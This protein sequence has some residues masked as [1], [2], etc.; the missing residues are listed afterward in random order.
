LTL[1]IVTGGSSGIGAACARAFAARGHALVLLGRRADRLEDVARECRAAGAAE[2]AVRAADVRDRAALERW[3]Q[4][5]AQR[6]AGADVLVNNAGLARGFGPL[7]ENDPSHWDEMLD[8]N[9]RGLLDVTRLVV[10]GMIARGTGDV[11]NVGSVAGRWTYPGGAAYCA[12]KAA[13]RVITEGLRM[14][15]L[16]KG[17]RVSTVDPGMVET[18][19]SLVRFS[20][21]APRAEAVYRGVTPLTAEDVA[22]TVAWIV[23]RPRRVNVAEVVLYPLDQAA[24][25]LVSR[26]S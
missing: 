5:D 20:G 6:I 23:E 15:L 1:S 25:T 14:D 2:V 21:D 8:T 24:P 19:F 9:V 22:E 17:V 18:E 16:G 4:E 13:E 11:V 10:P 12:S 7:H 3:A 26:R